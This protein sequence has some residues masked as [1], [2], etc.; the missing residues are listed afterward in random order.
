M[1]SRPQ[2]FLGYRMEEQCQERDKG[3]KTGITGC[4]EN[5]S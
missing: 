1:V 4:K 5:V 3:V 2:S